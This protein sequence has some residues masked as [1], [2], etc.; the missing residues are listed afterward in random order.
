MK[1]TRRC[2][3]TS[4]IYI[5]I[6]SPPCTT[7]PLSFVLRFL[8]LPLFSG[9]PKG[10]GTRGGSCDPVQEIP[11]WERSLSVG[12]IFL[13]ISSTDAKWCSHRQTLNWLYVKEFLLFNEFFLIFPIVYSKHSFLVD[14]LDWRKPTQRFTI[15]GK[16]SSHSPLATVPSYIYLRYFVLC[17]KD[18]HQCI[19]SHF[20]HT[21]SLSY[22][23][24]W[25][26]RSKWR[27]EVPTLAPAQ[28][29]E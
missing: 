20:I 19:L 10:G 12:D 29:T 4:Y 27:S 7:P 1:E 28:C 21:S 14:Y 13:Y 3:Q 26:L 11:S 15:I 24:Q 16:I 23:I 8:S 2:L 25:R 22:R 6:S 17:S 9:V 5:P 18:R